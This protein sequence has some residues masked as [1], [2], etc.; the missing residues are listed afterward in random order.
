MS[1]VLCLHRIAQ[2]EP[3][4]DLGLCCPPEHLISLIEGLRRDFSIVP[5]RSL[6]STNPRQVALTFD[7]GYQDNFTLA[8]PILERFDVPATFFISSRYVES[9]TL[10]YWDSLRA[11]LQAEEFDIKSFVR[12]RDRIA[13]TRGKERWASIQ[14]LHAEALEVGVPDFLGRPLDQFELEE[15]SRHPLVTLGCHTAS[16]PSLRSLDRSE[17]LSEIRECL[18][19]LAKFPLANPLSRAIAFPFG[20]SEDCPA[21]SIFRAAEF[22]QGLTTEAAALTARPYASASCW[23]RGHE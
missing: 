5:L 21:K 6:S 8:L 13:K 9:G 14:N 15:L 19:Y 16:H 2:T 11:I 22:D 23:F 1:V 18:T 20:R 10:F 7:D 3:R 17:Q 4:S 12:Y